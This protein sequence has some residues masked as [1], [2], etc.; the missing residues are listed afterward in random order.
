[1]HSRHKWIGALV[2]AATV[3]AV[4]LVTASIVSADTSTGAISNLS[5]AKLKIVHTGGAVPNT[6]DSVI[7]RLTLPVGSWAIFADTSLYALGSP[8]TDV[9]CWLTAPNASPGFDETTMSG[10]S[11]VDSV[12]SLSLSTVTNAPD[13][14]NVDLRCRVT[15]GAAD[16][17]I[18]ERT[19]RITAI[20]VPGVTS[21]ENPPPALGG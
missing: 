6:S 15:N 17:L 9:Q 3:A 2:L 13:G 7:G 4:A 18:R 11:A 10:Q 20:S 16:R 12:R 5:P 1:M 8:A 19:T 14:G 21:T